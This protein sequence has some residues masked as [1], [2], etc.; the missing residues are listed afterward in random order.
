MQNRYAYL[1][2]LT[3]ALFDFAVV[4]AAIYMAF[5]IAS[6]IAGN[7]NYIDF[8]LII[9]LF[10]F[11][12]SKLVELYDSKTLQRK[13]F[14]ITTVKALCLH[15]IFF[16][17]YNS[18]KGFFLTGGFTL[19]FYSTLALLL[20]SSRYFAVLLS[21]I[22][23]KMFNMARPIAL[24]G[25]NPT[26]MLLADFFEKNEKLYH[27]AGFLNQNGI[28][29][30]V[31]TGYSDALL[32]EQIKI[33][34]DTGINEI[35]VCLAPDRLSEISGLVEEAHKQCIRL[36]F[37]PDYSQIINKPLSIQQ[38]SDLQVISL[39]G[40]GAQEEMDDRVIKRLFDIVFSLMVVVFIFSWLYP[41]LA[42]LIKLESPGPVIFKQGRSGRNNV[43]FWCYKFRSMRVNQDSNV[44]QASRDD[45]R[46][47]K[48]GHF[49][50]R[51]S[52]DELPQFF[53]VL[54]GNMSIV[55]PRPHMLKHTEHYRDIVDKYMARH[56]MK[57]G[58]TG[59]AQV[60]GYRGET[61]EL[62][63]MEKRVEHDLW[64]LEN[65]SASL[66]MKIL[67]M[68]IGQVFKGHENAF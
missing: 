62:H 10:W 39:T 51:T 11:L 25:V 41:I 16:L 52:L 60:N 7:N 22:M 34:A 48:M 28:L 50:R 63:L 36:K 40:S 24:F 1:F 12:A 54:L 31:K 49:L 67:L 2:S 58:I 37:V 68:T 5:K 33:A 66:D 59:W 38:L 27:F 20:L 30:D 8:A 9:S 45:A 26:S 13:L 64:Y 42:I 32:K 17:L 3:M 35:Y 43:N 29:P 55:G 44:K 47:T 21:P 57:P 56:Y 23:K 14:I 65:W 53:N 46:I 18:I 15:L 19:A 6:P 4:N 61:Q